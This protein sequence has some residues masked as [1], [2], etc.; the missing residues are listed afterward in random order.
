MRV[1][2]LKYVDDPPQPPSARRETAAGAGPPPNPLAGRLTKVPFDVADPSAG[3]LIAQVALF[4]S[5]YDIFSGGNVAVCEYV[6]PQGEK[7]MIVAHGGNKHS[8]EQ[9]LAVLRIESQ[10]GQVAS[11]TRLYT[12]R[13]PCCH[14][15]GGHNCRQRLANDPL[16]A[17][18]KVFYTF[19]Y[20]GPYRE[21]GVKRDGTRDAGNAEA[22][23]VM[24]GLVVERALQA[25]AGTKPG[26]HA[27]MQ[28]QAGA[29]GPAV[30][31]DAL[32]ND[33]RFPDV[34]DEK[35]TAD[36]HT[37]TRDRAVAAPA[38]APTAAS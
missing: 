34:F 35:T 16:F 9:I 7:R 12:E 2:H 23:A 14:S 29:Q 28:A 1:Y 36:I 30:I 19:D 17:G 37:A 38:A 31:V 8:E 21:G 3:D 5:Q 13:E 32:P 25:L 15:S 26:L 4:R 27:R 18:A 20:D 24:N 33:L 11:V 6:T 22:T 10:N